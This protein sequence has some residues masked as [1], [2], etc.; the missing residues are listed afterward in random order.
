MG[1]VSGKRLMIAGTGSGCG[2]TTATCGIL[3]GLKKRGLS[4]EAWKSG[5]DYIDP[6]FHR[7]V[8]GTTSGNLDLY[9]SGVEG[10]RRLLA[11]RANDAD[12]SIV[13]GAMGYYDGIGMTGEAGCQAL[14]E[15]TGLPVILVVS[16]QGMGQSVGALLQ[17]FCQYVQ[18]SRIAGILFNRVSASQYQRL[19]PLVERMGLRAVG[20]IPVQEAFVPKSRHLGLVTAD[21]IPDFQEQMER[22]Y[23]IVETTL[24]W[25]ALLDL[26]ETA[27]PVSFADASPEGN[28]EG[29]GLRIGIARD[30]AFCFFYEDN[31]RWLQRRG[32]Q[33]IPFSPLRDRKLP[34]E[35]DGMILCGGY[36]ELHARELS[37]NR[38]MLTEIKAALQRGMPCIAECGGYLY[39]QQDLTDDKG[40]VYPL[41]GVF[42][43][44][45]YCKKALE[46]FGYIAISLSGSRLFGEKEMSLRAHE[47]HYYDCD[48]PGSALLAKKASGTGQWATGETGETYYAGFP[49]LFF[50]G[51]ERFAEGFLRQ[52]HSYHRRQTVRVISHEPYAALGREPDQAAR[53]A[54]QAQW[55]AVAKPLRGLGR[56]EDM[57]VRIAG[58]Q[59]NPAIAIRR[60]AVLVFCGDNGITAQGVTQTGS[61]VTAL[62]ADNIADGKASVNRMCAQ[63]GTDVYAIDMGIRDTIH[64]L[65]MI[66]CR[67]ADGTRDF[68]Q[69]PAMSRAQALQAIET[70][71]GL[72]RDFRE[73]GYTILATGEMGIGNTT[74]AGAMAAA[75]LDLPV[76]KVAGRGAGLSDEGLARKRLVIE[77]ALRRYGLRGSDPLTILS[78][79]GGFD[80]AGMTGAFIGGCMYGVPVVIDGMIS[81]VAALTA[82]LLCERAVTCML[83][84]HRSREPAMA[85]VME[86][87]GLTPVIDGDL[88]LGEGTG[89][90]LLFPMLDM[91]ECVY[92]NTETFAEMQIE[93]YQKYE[94]KW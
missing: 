64:S 36:P 8:L 54:A 52:A 44:H 61:H 49:H 23:R 73:R 41:A 6:M 48:R 69:E 59:G 40:Q 35:L 2:K 12:I 42:P 46:R 9:F 62:V 81:A 24:D 19:R 71:I 78:H 26:A 18:P 83:A 84:S 63:S 79:V 16:P 87:L 15:A 4:V 11:L 17:G 21:E 3:Y 60:R 1:T 90:A 30:E 85:L 22:F 47:F 89:A 57:V 29:A 92:K 67:V 34:A 68:S 33:L 58:I 55:D 75:L 66:S 93:T 28:K 14:A 43:G 7:R 88:A 77:E 31:L 25:Q 32:C 74:T 70:G 56:L 76:R 53:A 72:V 82:S 50:E 45:G 10:V 38:E 94:T 86:R 80:I 91:A 27:R 13:E 65:S 20:Y 51:N 5:P 37:A 39:L